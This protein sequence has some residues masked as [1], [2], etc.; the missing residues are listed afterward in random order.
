MT[1]K[2]CSNLLIEYLEGLLPK[3]KQTLI[4]KHLGECKQC[5][6]ELEKLETTFTI[7]KKDSIPPLSRAKKRALFPM[8]MERVEE[9]AK[10]RRKLWRYGLSFASALVII[11]LVS[12]VVINNKKESDIYTVFTNPESIIYK[13]DSIINN[14]LLE[15]IVEIDTIINGIRT[16]LDDELVENTQLA[17]L[18]EQLSEDEVNELVQKLSTIDFNGG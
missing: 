17:S 18:V 9:K 6:N 13:N 2:E 5:R 1:C 15:S 12:L 11:F 8:V 7:M 14:Y 16:N 3:S 4:K 10:K